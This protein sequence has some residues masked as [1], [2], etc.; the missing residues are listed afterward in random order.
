MRH[1]S[2]IR[3]AT[4]GLLVVASVGAQSGPADKHLALV[5]PLRTRLRHSLRME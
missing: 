4:L 5:R 2:V 1:A 3:A